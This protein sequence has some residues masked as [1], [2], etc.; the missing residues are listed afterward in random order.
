MP[1][2]SQALDRLYQTILSRKGGDPAASYTARLFEKGLSQCAK[3]L[4]E[5]GVEAALAG[6]LGDRDGLVA[7]SAD[8]L[9]HLLVMWA[10]LGIAPDEVYA[11][12]AEREGKS[13]LK[14]KASRGEA[15]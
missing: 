5:E 2:D 4:G 14:E 6:A 9:Y 10:A 7:E 12:L 3:K 11:R 15:D 8:L 13:G 1:T